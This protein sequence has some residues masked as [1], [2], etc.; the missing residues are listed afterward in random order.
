M[1]R[2]TK[3]IANARENTMLTNVKRM[4][5]VYK[6][7]GF[8][9][10]QIYGDNEFECIVDALRMDCNVNFYPVAR[11]AHEPFIERDNRTS[12]E[13]CRC[14]FNSLPFKH[15]PT[16][17]TMELPIAVDFWL[18]YWCSSGGVSSTVPPTQ[19]VTGIKLDAK[20]HCRFQFGDYVLAHGD[21]NNTMGARAG[22]SIYL[23]PT[24]N[25]DGGFY[26][27]DL[28]TARKVHRYSATAAHM[29]QS[30][31]DR[32]HTIAAEQQAPKGFNLGGFNDE[33]TIL[34][35]DDRSN[36]PEEEDDDE[37]SDTTYDD[38]DD[39]V[40][41][42]LTDVV[43]DDED[44]GENY[45]VNDDANNGGK[46][47]DHH[48]GDSV[49]S[50]PEDEMAE[51]TPQNE[52]EG[53]EEVNEPA[54]DLDNASNGNTTNE[55][56][57]LHNT[58][59][60]LRPIVRPP[61]RN[62]A[63]GFTSS[64][65][66]RNMFCM[67]YSAA[68]KRLCEN[69]TKIMLVSAAVEKYNNLEASLV[70]PQY[71]VK[72]GL[73]LFQ[74]KGTE[75]I[76]KELK[77]LD[78]LNVISPIHP[79]DM[80]RDDI[81]RALPYLMFLKR[82][83]C[84]KIKARGCADGRSQREFIS[85]DEASSPTAS[86]HAIML[87]SLIDAIEE[88]V[89][90]T[91]DI[92][93]AFLQTDMPK[94]EAPV[95]IRVDG[96]MADILLQIDPVKYGKCVVTNKRGNKIIFARANKAIYGTL[97]AALLFW[98]KLH[99]K[100]KEWGFEQNPYD[101]CT[102][103]K[104]I[105]GK[106]A[107][108]VWHVDDLKISHDSDGVVKQIIADLDSEFGKISPLTVHI[109]KVHDYLGMTIDYS[110]N[111]RAKFSMFDYLEDIIKNLPA[112]L[113]TTRNTS[114]PAAEHLFNVDPKATKLTQKKA[115][116]F[117]HYVA[118]LLFAAKRARPDIQTAVAFLCTR[119]KSPDTDD[120]KKLQRVLGYIRDTIFL[121]LT[122]GWDKTGHLYWYVDAAFAVHN[123]MKSHT[124]ALMTCGV[125]AVL[126]TS[127]KQKLN[128]KSSTEAELVAVDDALPFNIWCLYFLREQGYHA[129][130]GKEKAVKYLGHTNVLY[131]DNTSSIKL[132]TN[133]KLSSTKRTR[134]IAIRYFMITDRVKQKEI[135]IEYCPTDNMLADYLSKPQQGSLFRRM[136]NAVMG[137]S[138][139]EFIKH[140][141]AYESARKQRVTE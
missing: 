110:E 48:D 8:N 52:D 59:R 118:K 93:G 12:K 43:T 30:V 2:I 107:T 112:D 39:S 91:V 34:D 133:G 115:D 4:I 74:Q 78:D 9:V 66:R 75:A 97:K 37:A 27:F 42:A 138:D 119:V 100:L 98:G 113:R 13:R 35:L 67:G 51:D 90:A 18:N 136:R 20:K 6:A 130:G 65:T 38:D 127:L 63:E 69:E 41:T 128:T 15:W 82:K 116:E 80:T 46:E 36:V 25:P 55:D 121:P 77:Q 123:D 60:T 89:V 3:A 104:M 106:Q 24:G 44:D 10:V 114:T 84:G 56:N 17:M 62:E 96:A 122:I 21:S 68:M 31:I 11:N 140:K 135:T 124:G 85:R 45:Y 72:Q 137:A 58:K 16:R 83:R 32:V 79:W 109:G 47:T 125:G 61:Q 54:N 1:L 103:N 57:E 49:P 141:M 81:K 88:R 87:T 19:L 71:G 5:G 139:A 28:A 23:R 50:L 26:V 14:V 86:L 33:T 7:R 29:T 70:T 94:D 53:Y 101:R 108:V 76:L 102:M 95:F 22:E 64:V 129:A 131:Q 92:P 73:R 111:G 126:S 132:E 117:H 40:D 134:H 99:S 120:W 105:E